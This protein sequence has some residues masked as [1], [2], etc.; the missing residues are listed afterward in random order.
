MK[1]LLIWLWY[2]TQTV[3]L[4][5]VIY[6]RNYTLVKTLFLALFHLRCIL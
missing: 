1:Y 2:S 5:Q 3:G 6:T 4:T